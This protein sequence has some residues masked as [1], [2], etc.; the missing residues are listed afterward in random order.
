MIT[1]LHLS[2]YKSVTEQTI[3]LG[4]V[5]I[6]VG[7]NGSGKSNII[8]AIS[9]M[10]DIA[11]YDLDY[12]VTKRH[13]ADSIRQWSKYRPYHTTVAVKVKNKYGEGS[14]SITFSSSRNSYRIQEEVISWNGEIVFSDDRQFMTL[15]RD[16][17][18]KV[19]ID[20]DYQADDLDPNDLKVDSGDSVLARLNA[21]YHD[22]NDVLGYVIRELRSFA[23]FT[24]FPNTIRAPQTV[25]RAAELESDG[26]NIASIIKQM[27]GDK[28][29]SRDRLIK[30]LKV[31]L[32]ELTGI[33]IRSTAGYYVPVFSVADNTGEVHELN[34]SQISDGT[35]RML[36]ILTALHQPSAPLKIGLEEPE[37][38]IHPALLII[39]RDAVLEYV[40]RRKEGQIFVTTHSSVLMDLFDVNDVIAVEYRDGA[41]RC[42][43]VSRRQAKV[44]K[45]GLMSLGDLMLAEDLEIA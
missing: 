8:D 6:F 10:S 3:P 20:T 32:P 40:R 12:A 11:V 7:K 21:S 45:T 31:V 30:A 13:G 44:V 2:H 9:F 19:T 18:S 37:Q 42:G 25:S 4:Q 28:K 35:L 14:Y 43:R 39:V 41:T 22:A 29:R 34:M 33:S 26:K 15:K 36:G 17:D 5:N 23:T 1:E 16:S 27:T 38:M 24:I